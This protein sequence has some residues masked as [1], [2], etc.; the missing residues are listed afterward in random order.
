MEVPG[1]EPLDVTQETWQ[2]RALA[3][4]LRNGI[5]STV[6]MF[7]IT[8]A[9]AVPPSWIPF[10]SGVLQVREIELDFPR[11]VISH[12]EGVAAPDVQDQ[13]TRVADLREHAIR[14]DGA[15][16][17]ERLEAQA[18]LVTGGIVHSYPNPARGAAIDRRDGNRRGGSDQELRELR[19]ED[20]ETLE[21]VDHAFSTAV[22]DTV[23]ELMPSVFRRR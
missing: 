13:R 15:A 18:P 10:M 2:A 21:P 5:V 22:T 4:S 14:R 12:T 17:V 11:R 23:I 3:P 6:G 19:M 20:L 9:V 8:V 7:A 16:I 1:G